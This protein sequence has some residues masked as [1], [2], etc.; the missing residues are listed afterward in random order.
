MGFRIKKKK[1]LSLSPE[2]TPFQLSEFEQVF[3][4]EVLWVLKE[5][6]I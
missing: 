2:S 4:H 3:F 6:N 5:I 1:N